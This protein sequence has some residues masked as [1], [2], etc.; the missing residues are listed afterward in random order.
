LRRIPERP[1]H[2]PA[3]FERRLGASVIQRIRTGPAY[4]DALIQLGSIHQAE[5]DLVLGQG[6]QMSFGRM[7]V[8]AVAA[9]GQNIYY[10]RSRIR[11]FGERSMIVDRLDK[12]ILFGVNLRII[13]GERPDRII[14]CRIAGRNV[15]NHNVGPIAIVSACHYTLNITQ[16]I[17]AYIFGFFDNKPV[18]ADKTIYIGRVPVHY[19]VSGKFL[20]VRWNIC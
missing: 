8:P 20:T 11:E 15:L 17:V 7:I 2:L 18:L 13:R 4:H 12:H 6:G 5:V 10:R 14:G 3:I 1:K 9:I 16:R 19:R